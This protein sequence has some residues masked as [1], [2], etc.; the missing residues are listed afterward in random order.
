L[1]QDGVL[2]DFIGALCKVHGRANPYTNPASLG[3]FDTEKLWGISE[4]EFWAPIAS[5]SLE[6]WEGI[7]KTPE[8]DEIVKLA[9]LEFGIDNVCILTAPS[10]DPGSI[11]G[12]R[13]WMARHYPGF[14]KKMIFAT[15]SA[16][17]F[18]S[19]PGK[20]LIDD[21]D[22]NVDEF[23]EAGGVGILVPRPWNAEHFLEPR[24]VEVVKE[25]I[26]EGKRYGW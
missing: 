3:H 14:E 2:A 7:D 12:K 8:A 18:C 1:D 24:L 25:Q 10:K 4:T 21:K 17:K 15:A 5:N 6:F 20:Y 13:A 9:V 19:A 16:K 11:P 22:S 23:D 26:R